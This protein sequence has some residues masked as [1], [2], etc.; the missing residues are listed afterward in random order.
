MGVGVGGELRRWDELEWESR[1]SGSQ[2]EWD[3]GGVG[4]GAEL[5][6]WDEF[7]WVWEW[8]VVWCGCRCRIVD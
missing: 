1:W 4:E 6:R 5:R 7:E 3:G 2:V 8:G